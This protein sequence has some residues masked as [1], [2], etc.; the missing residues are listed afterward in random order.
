MKIMPNFSDLFWWT[1]ARKQTCRRLPVCRVPSRLSQYANEQAK[2]AGNEA[3]LFFFPS[4]IPMV[5]HVLLISSW[6]L[7]LAC[8]NA[9]GM[10]RGSPFCA[11]PPAQE[12]L[13]AGV[14]GSPYYLTAFSLHGQRFGVLATMTLY[15]RAYAFL[16]TQ[17]IGH[18]R[19]R[20]QLWC[21]E[22]ILLIY[23]FHFGSRRGWGKGGG[24]P[25][26]VS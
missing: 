19:A 17:H 20:E 10:W 7:I 22:L 13:L 26:P 6:L 25:F 24:G 23:S 21:P 5:P 18:H 11:S 4:F 16:S 9:K 1:V 15:P 3:T 12:S 14:L 2:E 8:S